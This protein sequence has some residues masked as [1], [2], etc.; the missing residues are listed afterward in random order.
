[1]KNAYGFANEE[2]VDTFRSLFQ[3]GNE[4]VVTP[5]VTSIV[6]AHP[7]LQYCNDF[8][9]NSVEDIN[10]LERLFYEGDTRS[11]GMVNEVPLESYYKNKSKVDNKSVLNLERLGY[12]KTI[13]FTFS[14]LSEAQFCAPKHARDLH[15]QASFEE[16]CQAAVLSKKG[17]SVTQFQVFLPNKNYATDNIHIQNNQ[18]NTHGLTY[19]M[20]RKV[21]LIALGMLGKE[22][23]VT[24]EFFLGSQDTA[25]KNES[26]QQYHK[27]FLFTSLMNM[28]R[29]GST[30]GVAMPRY[31]D[32][33]DEEIDAVRFIALLLT[34]LTTS[35]DFPWMNNGDV[36]YLDSASDRRKLFA[37][38]LVE[39]NSMEYLRFAVTVVGLAT[40]EEPKI[41]P[42]NP[43]IKFLTRPH[44]DRSNSQKRLFESTPTL[45]FG[46]EFD[47][48]LLRVSCIGNARQSIDCVMDALELHGPYINFLWKGYDAMKKYRRC[49]SQEHIATN[50]VFTNSVPGLVCAKQ[51]CNLDPMGHLGT[52]IE[53]ICRLNDSLKLTKLELYSIWRASGVCPHSPYVF[54]AAC[55]ALIQERASLRGCH[56]RYF[57]LGYLLANCIKKIKRCLNEDKQLENPPL[58]HN[59]YR[60][61]YLPSSISEWNTDCEQLLEIGFDSHKNVPT[62]SRSRLV[63]QKAYSEIR[64]KVAEVFPNVQHLISNHLCG[65]AGAINCL[66]FWTT[67]EIEFHSS[68]PIVWFLEKFQLLDQATVVKAP[69]TP[70]TE[71]RSRLT[72]TTRRR[73][74]RKPKAN[75]IE[76]KF[77]NTKAAMETRT[78]EIWS[79]RKIE[80]LKCKI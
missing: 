21:S 70:T 67:Q 4:P 47:G 40:K 18:M 42:A 27:D 34:K 32:I 37:E 72:T 57:N 66:P 69:D 50:T 76:K 33:G 48:L 79:W 63:R 38:R 43:L 77:L 68:K 49:L 11:F 8:G 31:K 60:D 53:W 35:A 6:N 20:K 54:G 56:R 45:S 73:T 36:P 15:Y 80:N 71:R 12:L 17:G 65:I 62:L 75:M 13:T 16:F 51:F 64:A 41:L 29:T 52:F 26:R 3:R 46:V 14:N 2:Q 44:G 24:K 30:F 19:E 61:I 55:Q 28:T 5:S 7:C 78:G 22:E 25:N 23:Q 59:L 39:G 10:G 1:M 9:L 58:R 74:S